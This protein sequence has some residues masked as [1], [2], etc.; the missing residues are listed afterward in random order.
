MSTE[1]PKPAM[2]ISLASEP[3][4]RIPMFTAEQ[5]AKFVEAAIN[6]HMGPD[7]TG[8][9]LEEFRAAYCEGKV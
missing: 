4:L 5:V 9:P 6:D 1:L 2:V 3:D 7:Y 8:A